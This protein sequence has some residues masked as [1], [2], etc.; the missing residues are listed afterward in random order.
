[1]RYKASTWRWS[2]GQ[3]QPSRPEKY[4]ERLDLSVNTVVK[5]VAGFNPKDV[6]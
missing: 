5:E 4:R 2:V 1:M 3:R 6:L